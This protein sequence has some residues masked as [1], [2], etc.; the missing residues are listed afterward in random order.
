[1]MGSNSIQSTANQ[2]KGKSFDTCLNIPTANNYIS[3]EASVG[4]SGMSL[5]YYHIS[6]TFSP[7]VKSLDFLRTR[8]IVSYFYELF[9]FDKHLV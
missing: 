3:T 6:Y 1:M 2:E 8:N 5:H 7:D 9:R 4:Y